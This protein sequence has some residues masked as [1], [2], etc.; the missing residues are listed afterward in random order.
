MNYR[1]FEH[2]IKTTLQNAEEPVD[3]AWLMDAIRAPKK[4]K[5]PMVLWFFTGFTLVALGTFAWVNANQSH[6]S[7]T[8][9]TQNFVAS[10]PS[11]AI[12]VPAA[13]FAK[14]TAVPQAG[15]LN[16]E[17]TAPSSPVKKQSF[18]GNISKI[19]NFNNSNSTPSNPIS[20]E[21]HANSDHNIIKIANWVEAENPTVEEREATS[22]SSISNLNMGLTTENRVTLNREVECPTFRKNRTMKLS[23][24]PEVGYFRPFKKLSPESNPAPETYSLRNE[25]EKSLEGLQAALYARLQRP[26]SNWGVSTGFHY[27]RLTER[28]NLQY[29]Y[30]KSDTTQGIISITVSQTGDTI[31]TIYGDIITQT[32]VTGTTKSHYTLST[33]DIPLSLF[34]EKDFESWSLGAEAGAYFNLALVSKGN[35]LSSVNGFVDVKTAAAFKP[36]LGVSGFASVYVKKAMGPGNLFLALRGRFIPSAFNSQGY[37]TVQK[38]QFVGAHLG[39]EFRF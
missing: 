16:I 8:T 36:S 15:K 25:S 22:V 7:M 18:S 14:P 39:Y 32:R 3:V 37:G 31:T 35:I 10:A 1:N 13:D 17:N 24:I 12:T 34:Y 38:Y 21:E 9:T 33:F 5:R 30:L 29:T 19:Q 27:S 23:L 28:M 11:K 2:S 20:N 26:G 4:K 6:L